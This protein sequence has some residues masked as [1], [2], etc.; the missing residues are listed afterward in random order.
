MSKSESFS[1]ITLDKIKTFYQ[2]S[3]EKSISKAGKILGKPRHAMYYELSYI[4]ELLETK[5]YNSGRKSLTLTSEGIEFSKFCTDVVN[6]INEYNETEEKIYEGTIIVHT[7]IGLGINLFPKIIKEFNLLYPKFSI[8]L[9]TGYEQI[10][11]KTTNFD[12]L[13]GPHLNNR[14]DLTQ[15]FLRN[16]HYSYY[17]SQEYLDQNGRPN[18]ESE[19]KNHVLLN[20]SGSTSIPE[21]IINN[22]N[23]LVFESNSFPALNEMCRNSIGIGMFINEV[24]NYFIGDLMKKK[25]ILLFPDLI[26]RTEPM[27]AIFPKSAKYQTAIDNLITIVKNTLN[28]I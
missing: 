23:K 8:R 14:Q 19:L 3:R 9:F 10:S 28:Q 15:T 27:Y 13:I 6:R 16:Y 5:L 11:E 1:K 21:N 24:N 4:E 26:I 20:Y 22:C 2:V 17:A 18:S 12:L 25:L 7:T